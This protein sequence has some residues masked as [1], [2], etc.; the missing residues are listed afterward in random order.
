MEFAFKYGIWE[1]VIHDLTPEAQLLAAIGY[2]NH[3]NFRCIRDHNLTEK[4]CDLC[5]FEREWGAQVKWENAL[6]LCIAHPL[7]KDRLQNIS[8]LYDF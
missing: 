2:G 6:N 8:V 7:K 4:F 3:L 1:I 5:F